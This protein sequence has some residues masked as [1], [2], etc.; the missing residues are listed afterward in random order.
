MIV[1]AR[2]KWYKNPEMLVALSAL[3]IG[4]VTAVISIY[5]AYIDRAYAKAS[6]WPRIEIYR[7]YGEQKFSYGVANKGT[8]PAIFHYAK[9]SYNDTVIKRWSERKEFRHIEQSHIGNI[10]L[11]AGQSVLPVNYKGEHTSEILAADPYMYIELCY[12]SIYDDCWVVDR[13]NNPK[14]V[15]AC[16]IG[17]SQMFLQ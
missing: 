5:S 7:S 16:S 11:P 10:T 15:E 2:V 17:E 6:V 4:L 13:N 1:E 8:G 3:F 12:C 14:S 9:I